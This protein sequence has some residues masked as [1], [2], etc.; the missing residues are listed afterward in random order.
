MKTITMNNEECYLK[1]LICGKLGGF[2]L[3]GLNVDINLNNNSFDN[4][5]YLGTYFMRSFTEASTIMNELMENQ[6]I[7]NA[8]EDKEEINILDIGSGTGGN[9]TGVLAFLS[10]FGEA[11]KQINIYSIDGNQN[12]LDYQEY[13]VDKFSQNFDINCNLER[14]NVVFK[15]RDDFENQVHT[16]LANLNVSFDLIMTFKFVSEFY[17]T[18]PEEARGFYECFIETTQNFLSDT[19]LMIILD[20]VAKDYDR[21]RFAYSTQILSKNMSNYFVKPFPKLACI[22]PLSCA[23][24]YRTCSTPTCYIERVFTVNN[25]QNVRDV[26][27][28]CYRVLT[29]K[30]FAQCILN[31]LDKKKYYQISFNQKNPA[32]CIDGNVIISDIEK[33]KINQVPTAFSF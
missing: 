28:V 10:K 23:K 1:N 32:V 14:L 12:A 3:K 13:I 5:K 26:S 20:V 21:K 7:S 31:S 9:I 4:K 11:N 6:K 24:W 18:N 30:M 8:W 29:Q 19:G 33:I 25:C 16:L 2:Y 17:N 22:L 15:N 27:K